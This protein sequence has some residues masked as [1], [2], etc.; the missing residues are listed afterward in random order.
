MI[1]VALWI[2]VEPGEGCEK[3]I[4]ILA[5]PIHAARCGAL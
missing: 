2:A 5:A 1:L 3:R 4:M